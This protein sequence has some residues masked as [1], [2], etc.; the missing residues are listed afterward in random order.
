MISEACFDI[1]TQAIRA[2]SLETKRFESLHTTV[3][4]G[5]GRILEDPPTAA[6]VSSML[7]ENE[8]S[9]PIK[10]HIVITDR[11]FATFKEA[12]ACLSALAC[13]KLEIKEC[14][15]LILKS[16]LANAK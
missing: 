7:T 13:R 14:V 8:I 9:G 3:Q 4:Y 15:Y 16:L 5:T 2:Y 1:I 10:V 11:W 6:Q 12:G